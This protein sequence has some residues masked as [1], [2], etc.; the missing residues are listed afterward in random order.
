MV[1]YEKLVVV[2]VWVVRRRFDSCFHRDCNR[3]SIGA[4]T[5]LLLEGR[6]SATLVNHFHVFILVLTIGHFE[7]D[8]GT[9]IVDMIERMRFQISTNACI[10]GPTQSNIDKT[11]LQ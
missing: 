10:S 9:V 7:E 11:V 2:Y 4:I 3:R 1:L 5:S 6:L 8:Q